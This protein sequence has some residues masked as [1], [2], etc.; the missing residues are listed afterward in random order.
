MAARCLAG[1]PNFPINCLLRYSNLSC[2]S[3]LSRVEQL[4]MA[5]DDFETITG[6]NRYPT[7]IVIEV[8]EIGRVELCSLTRIFLAQFPSSIQPLLLRQKA[9]LKFRN[10]LG[11]MSVTRF[12]SPRIS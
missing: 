10:A 5:R 11:S 7:D 3:E 9:A 2:R 1:F 6:C 12:L 4:R 8:F